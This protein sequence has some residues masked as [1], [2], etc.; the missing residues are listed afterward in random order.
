MCEQQISLP[1]DLVGGR[2]DEGCRAALAATWNNL[3]RDK[4]PNMATHNNWPISLDHCFMRVCLDTV[5]GQPWHLAIKRPAIRHLT[6]EQLKRAMEVAQG[7]ILDPASLDTL[8]RQSIE[9]RRQ[10][11]AKISKFDR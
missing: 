7:L 6:D 5:C 9:W 1:F 11:A 2:P 4:L 10:A 8:N 3:V